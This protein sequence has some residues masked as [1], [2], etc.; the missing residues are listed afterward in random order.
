MITLSFSASEFGQ[1][2][3]SMTDGEFTASV[4]AV[5][6][7]DAA[8]DL[9]A[10]LDS[11]ATSGVGECFWPREAGTH[12]WLIRRENGSVRLA[13]LWSGG[14]LT[15]WEHVFWAEDE[16]SGFERR[17]RLLLNSALL[18]STV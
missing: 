18:S 16:W 7:D 2:N 13:V 12:R 15:G 5:N 3:C 10:A 14:T 17:L 9:L 6:S 1:L 11:A 4:S 8:Q